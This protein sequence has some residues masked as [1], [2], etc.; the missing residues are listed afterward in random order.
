[1]HQNPVA[2]GTTEHNEAA[3][4]PAKVTQ[5]FGDRISAISEQARTTLRCYGVAGGNQIYNYPLTFTKV[6]FVLTQIP[7]IV[8]FGKHA[9]YLSL[10]NSNS[11][12]SGASRAG[13]RTLR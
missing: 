9:P 8:A 11:I 7:N 6:A 5:T 10:A 12:G 2:I 4:C 13:L 1:M 3:L